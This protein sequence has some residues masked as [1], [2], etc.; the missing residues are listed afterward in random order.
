MRIET[1][2]RKNGAVTSSQPSL[3]SRNVVLQLKRARR[4][5]NKMNNDYLM[6]RRPKPE[7]YLK[8]AAVTQYYSPEK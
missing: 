7:K 4:N 6:D 3:L 2:S 1:F 8:D 5:K